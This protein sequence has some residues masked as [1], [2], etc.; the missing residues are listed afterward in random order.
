MRQ[1]KDGDL[2]LPRPD[3]KL[4][5]ELEQVFAGIEVP[6]VHKKRDRHHALAEGNLDDESRLRDEDPARGVQAISQ[7]MLG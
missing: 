6:L 5:P 7:L 2:A 1:D 4:V 3:G